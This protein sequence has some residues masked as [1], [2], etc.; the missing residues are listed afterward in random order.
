MDQKDPGQVTILLDRVRQGDRRAE[1]QLFTLVND[2][3]RA[4]ARR[5]RYVGRPGE[6]MQPTALANEAY[7][8]LIR[9]MPMP[10]A[11]ERGGREW[12]FRI[13]AWA[14]RE[15]LR[16]YWR[17]KNAAKRGGREALGALGE[18]DPADR[19]GD[20]LGN[21]DF[22]ALDEALTN[23]EQYNERWFDIVMHRY[24]AGRTLEET[25][26][27]MGLGLTTVKDDWKLARAWLGRELDG[28]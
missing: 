27:L 16:D 24:F 4:I 9:R 3:L 14:M 2:E 21:T 13:V 19:R 7:L 25:A 28:R 22:L 6:T 11:D 18:H 17:K 20:R 8:H 23:L 15:I 26:E 5:S 1:D 10:P 12:F